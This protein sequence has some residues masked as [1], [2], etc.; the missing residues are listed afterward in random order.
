[1]ERIKHVMNGGYVKAKIRG[2]WVIGGITGHDQDYIWFN[3]AT[4]I[5]MDKE[6]RIPRTKAYKASSQE[7]VKM[8]QKTLEA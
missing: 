4:E 7:Y 8:F 5:S 3:P 1:M 2:K 6:I